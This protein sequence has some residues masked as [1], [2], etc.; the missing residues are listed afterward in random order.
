MS[1]GSH[2]G[3]RPDRNL[4]D[5]E[6]QAQ[7]VPGRDQAIITAV[8]SLQAVIAEVLSPGGIQPGAI[9]ASLTVLALLNLGGD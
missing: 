4:F 9:L 2:A 5:P 6:P 7:Q 3:L 1:K 8:T